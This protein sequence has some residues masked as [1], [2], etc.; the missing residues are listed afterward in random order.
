MY[1][2]CKELDC[3]AI[4]LRDEG[5]FNASLQELKTLRQ[6]GVR[7]FAEAEVREADTRHREATAAAAAQQPA[8]VQDS[9]FVTPQTRRHEARPSTAPQVALQ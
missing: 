1:S 8:T 9:S 6:A 2:D 5:T 4:R 7:T 3:K